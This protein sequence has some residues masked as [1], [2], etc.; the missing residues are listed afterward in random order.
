MRRVD[1]HTIR[2]RASLCHEVLRRD[3]AADQA[4]LQ[5]GLRV[6]T[7][8][9]ERHLRSACGAHEARQEPG[10]AVTGDDA[11]LHEGLR[12]PRRLR[13]DPHVRHRGEIAASA[14]CRT[15]DRGDERHVESL[16]RERDL[17]DPVS[18]AVPHLVRVPTE[19]AGL[20][21]HLLHVAAGGESLARTGEDD[22]P[23]LGVRIRSIDRVDDR[24]DHVV[25]GDRVAAVGAVERPRLHV[26][27]ALDE[28]RVVVCAACAC[29]AG[30][31]SAVCHGD[32]SSSI[33]V[34]GHADSVML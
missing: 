10:A 22:D 26:S 28:Q 8:T 24:R 19:H 21:P 1:C 16:Q 25:V 6:D 14:H 13:R 17:L 9:G 7:V 33:Y 4:P 34:L 12:E 15:V 29:A 18:V 5:G 32:S 3:D 23:D 27:V 31:L 2:E 20:V 30:V 11:E